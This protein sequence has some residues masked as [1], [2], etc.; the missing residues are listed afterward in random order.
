M[1]A[2]ADATIFGIVLALRLVVPLLVFRY[3]LPSILASLVI[4]AVDQTVFQTFTDLDLTNYQSY[5]K[6]LDIYYLSL[7]YVSTMRNWAHIGAFEISRWLFYYRLVGVALFELTGAQYRTI[8]L[9]FPNTFEYFFIA[10]SAVALLW[11]PLSVS[12]RAWLL[13]AAAIWVFVKLPQ[14]WWIHVAQLDFTDAV[15]DHTWFAVTVVV[16]VIGGAAVLWFVVRPRLRPPD[17]ALEIRSEDL[18]G[19]LDRGEVRRAGR[20]ARGRVTDLLLLEKIVLVALITAIFASILP[21]VHASTL[22]IALAVGIVVTVDSAVGLAA[23]RAGRGF[24]AAWSSFLALAAVNLLLVLLVSLVLPGESRID[25]P[26]TMFFLL[27]LTLVVSLFD[28]YAPVNA[29]RRRAWEAR[30]AA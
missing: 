23:A 14:E 28:R 15:R 2:A 17:H 8:L 25:P 9:V 19:G 24:D 27:L 16:A 7:A 11:R 29:L 30:T 4:D 5:D 1:D 21:D 26:V 20:V 22:Q 10:L 12:T 18:P 6:A 13:T 3:P